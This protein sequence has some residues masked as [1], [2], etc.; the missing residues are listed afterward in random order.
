MMSPALLWQGKVDLRVIV[1]KE[2]SRSSRLSLIKI[3][4]QLQ[5]KSCTGTEMQVEMAKT[6]RGLGS[7][8]VHVEGKERPQDSVLNSARQTDADS[9]K[10]CVPTQHFLI[11]PSRVWSYSLLL[12]CWK[13]W[14][15]CNSQEN[16]WGR[17]ACRLPCT[18]PKPLLNGLR[19][20]QSADLASLP[21]AGFS[22]HNRWINPIT[23]W[24]LQ[25]LMSHFTPSTPSALTVTFSPFLS[26]PMRRGAGCSRPTFGPNEPK[27][28]NSSPGAPLMLL[29]TATKTEM[30][31]HEMWHKKQVTLTGLGLWSFCSHQALPSCVPVGRTKS[32][33]DFTKAHPLSLKQQK[34][35]AQSLPLSISLYPS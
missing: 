10:T 7:V 21:L 6:K 12:P 27:L 18:S 19:M 22:P 4:F 33:S 11:F 26:H 28:V 15:F 20:L 32:E 35:S 9:V 29:S 30:L 3:R 23:W 5:S 2:I 8:T 25:G 17:L 14:S 24:K 1:H 13:M 31:S 16:W 34:G